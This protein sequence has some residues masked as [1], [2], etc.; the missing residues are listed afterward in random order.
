MLSRRT[1]ALS[2]AVV[3]GI[4]ARIGRPL[5]FRMCRSS[6]AHLIRALI[7]SVLRLAF[8]LFSECT[9]IRLGNFPISIWSGN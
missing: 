9:I 1:L 2:A 8:F 3:A 7:P 4:A 6:A 5:S